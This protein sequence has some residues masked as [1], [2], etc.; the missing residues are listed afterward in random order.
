[1]NQPKFSFK[2]NVSHAV[3]C[4]FYYAQFD[5]LLKKILRF[6]P[7]ILYF[8]QNRFLE[9][10]QEE[11]VGEE[12]RQGRRKARPWLQASPQGTSDR[13]RRQHQ[14]Q[15]TTI[16]GANSLRIRRINS[17]SLL[18]TLWLEANKNESKH[19]TENR[20]ITLIK[21]SEGT[22][23]IQKFYLNWSVMMCR[24]SDGR[25]TLEFWT[26][27]FNLTRKTTLIKTLTLMLSTSYTIFLRRLLV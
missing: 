2:G 19:Q 11:R 25:I 10:R 1:M 22:L 17:S 9:P 15:R 7:S 24:D 6:W 14:G 16:L 8:I 4:C 13:S 23:S 18:Y 12:S 26:R 27:N 5:N 20:L 21:L 3:G